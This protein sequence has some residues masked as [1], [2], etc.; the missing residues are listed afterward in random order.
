LHEFFEHHTSFII[1]RG[2]SKIEIFSKAYK[3]KG[4]MFMAK[5]RRAAKKRATKRR[6]PAK[7]KRS[8]GKRKG[9]GL[10]TMTY[11]LSPELQ[12][13]VGSSRSTRPQV[14]KKVWHYIKAHK[15]QDAKHR[16]MINPDK[17]LGAV[18]G[19]RSID[20][21]KMAG[22]LSKHIKKS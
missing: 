13:I 10:T 17:K 5:K 9:G 15:L 21:L 1:R 8:G 14:V 7:K 16:R 11:G 18:L 6:A 3:R 2:K 22:A 20:M 4:G 19:N 12:A